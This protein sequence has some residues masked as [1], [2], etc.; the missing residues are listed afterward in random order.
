MSDPSPTAD[1]L[2]RLRGYLTVLARMGLGPRLGRRVGASDIVQETLFEAHR[3]LASYRGRT[4]GELL[5]W[6]RRILAN[7]LANVVRDHHRA[8]RS[9]DA[10]VSMDVFL[11]QSSLRIARSLAA[12][13]SSPSG[14]A[15]RSEGVLALSNALGRLP[16]DW[17]DIV[18]RH[19]IEEASLTAIAEERGTTKYQV[20]RDLRA[21]LRQLRAELEEHA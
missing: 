5:V 19:H 7:N 2:E 8:K 15:A 4:E 20:A 1:D 11:E 18:I 14:K 12:G 16:Q 6:A 3:D 13:T 9:V 17:L 10:E 21:A